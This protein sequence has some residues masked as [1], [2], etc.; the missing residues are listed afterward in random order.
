M[1]VDGQCLIGPVPFF[2]VPLEDEGSEEW[3][4]ALWNLTLSPYIISTVK[5]GLE[6]KFD[7]HRIQNL[8]CR[9][10]KFYRTD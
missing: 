4:S 8:K 10:K 2:N 9:N 1:H 6:V 7:S 3:F 5:K